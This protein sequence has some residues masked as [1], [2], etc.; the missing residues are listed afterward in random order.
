MKT[1]LALKEEFKKVTGKDW[2][3]G[4]APANAQAS[5]PAAGDAKEVLTARVN[6]QAEVVKNLKAAGAP[7]V[8]FNLS[9]FQP[10]IIF[11]I[12]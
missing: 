12:G 4:M 7:Q 3:P 8:T 10:L 6:Q 9:S 1:L 2:K 11:I 5:S